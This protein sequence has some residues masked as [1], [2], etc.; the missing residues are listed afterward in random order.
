MFRHIYRL[1][2]SF[3]SSSFCAFLTYKHN[4]LRCLQKATRQ[5]TSRP[6]ITNLSWFLAVYTRSNFTQGKGYVCILQLFM[7]RISN[8]NF[9][10]AT[11]LAANY[12]NLTLRYWNKVTIFAILRSCCFFE[13]LRII[14]MINYVAPS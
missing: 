12:C 8:A 3:S 9:S 10:N 13:T 14:I 4:A 7:C 1:S 6:W 5:E 11:R 2:F